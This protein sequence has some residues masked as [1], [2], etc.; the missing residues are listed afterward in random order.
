MRGRL[1]LLLSI[2]VLA[3]C[4]T[5]ADRVRLKTVKSE[6]S[7]DLSGRRVAVEVTDQRPDVPMDVVGH[8]K[9]VV[10]VTI[11][12][13]VTSDNVA[14]WFG[15]CVAAELRRMGANAEMIGPGGGSA[16]DIVH[17]DVKIAYAKF[18][19]KYS[20]E[21]EVNLTIRQGMAVPLSNRKFSGSASLGVE[22]SSDPET[23]QQLLHDAM[24]D[25]LNRMMPVIADTLSPST[26]PTNPLITTSVPVLEEL[27]VR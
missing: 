22:V 27:R 6:L 25:L 18:H 13:V 21:L 8:V 9:S 17:L 4:S 24:L 3:G 19:V 7:R 15:K 20:A 16:Q 14:K 11:A 2:V 10:G 1:V 26:N 12:E 5:S 23:F